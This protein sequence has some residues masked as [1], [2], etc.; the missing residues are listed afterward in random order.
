MADDVAVKILKSH[1]W[2]GSGS[3]QE[4]SAVG[5]DPESPYAKF[6]L[7]EVAVTQR[8]YHITGLSVGNFLI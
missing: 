1:F 5:N 3:W 8:K 6:L 7:M 4:T 2:I